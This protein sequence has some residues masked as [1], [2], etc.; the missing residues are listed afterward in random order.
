MVVLY[1]KII[2]IYFSLI[3]SNASSHQSKPSLGLITMNL[4]QTQQNYTWDFIGISTSSTNE[5]IHRLNLVD[6]ME[7]WAID[8]YMNGM[9]VNDGGFVSYLFFL[10]VLRFRDF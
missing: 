8:S 6:L 3:T 1:Y 10:T 9:M 4:F 2:I 7:V 5:I